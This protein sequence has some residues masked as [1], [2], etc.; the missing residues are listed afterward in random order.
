M[1]YDGYN[2]RAVAVV[3]AF[4]SGHLLGPAFRSRG[5]PVVHVRNRNAT[6]ERQLDTFHASDFRE[7]LDCTDPTDGTAERLHALGVRHLLAG[8]ES[9]SDVADLLATKMDLS[10][11]NAPGFA[12][13]RRDKRTMHRILHE[14]GVAVP[15]Q[16]HLNG[17][18]NVRWEV[19]GIPRGTVV[20]KPPASAGTDGVHLCHSAA[21]RDAAIDQVVA[22]A[23]TYGQENDGAVIQ[24]FLAGPEYMVNTVSVDGFHAAVEIWRSDKHVVDGSPVYDR[25]VLQDPSDTG[26]RELLAYVDQV[27]TRLGVRW[28]AAH[29][30]V[31]VTDRGPLLLETGTRLPGGHDPSLG[32]S[33]LGTSHLDEVVESYLAPDEVADRGP[34]RPL[35]RRALGVSLISPATGTLQRPLDLRPVT[36]LPSFHGI[37]LPLQVGD[38]VTRTVDLWT[39]P[40]GLYLCHEDADQLD[41]DYQAV[42][43]WEQ[44]EFTRAVVAD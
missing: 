1:L 26:I 39:K 22:Q 32:L 18:K 37:R 17:A 13:A 29:T 30:E 15:A 36:A 25:Q 14:Q 23:N 8:A 38:R 33:A 43:A 19:G 10:T 24:E 40:G 4:G 12:Q 2:A 5:V 44:S 27:L 6:F 34:V 42:R 41:R 7:A 35:R 11:A 9:G 31:I 16:Q 3:D 28:G 20:V 21:E